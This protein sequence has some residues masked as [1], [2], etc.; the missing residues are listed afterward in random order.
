M[1][2][3]QRDMAMAI[4]ARFVL[5]LE[6]DSACIP[7]MNWLC[8]N[9]VITANRKAITARPIRALITFFITFPPCRM[10]LQIPDYVTPSVFI[11]VYT[12]TRTIWPS[13]PWFY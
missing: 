7:M 1:A 8:I 9:T 4:N 12:K 6:N 13:G 2:G 11:Q 10:N 5:A 3:Q